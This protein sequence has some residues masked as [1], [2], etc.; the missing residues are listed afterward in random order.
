M[1]SIDLRDTRSR[2]VIRDYYTNPFVDVNEDFRSFF[3]PPQRTVV[4]R[5]IGSS[6][7]DIMTR[8]AIFTGN[9]AFL[10]LH[11]WNRKI[12]ALMPGKAHFKS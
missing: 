6:P 2:S 9:E 7:T 12:A 11:Q 5:S 3:R 4:D 8:K 10:P 1:G